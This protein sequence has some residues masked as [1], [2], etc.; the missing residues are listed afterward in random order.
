MTDDEGTFEEF[1]Q[2]RRGRRSSVSLL[3]AAEKG[4]SPFEK[5]VETPFSGPRVFS[6]FG[7]DEEE[8]ARALF[9]SWAPKKCVASPCCALPLSDSVL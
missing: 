4:P 5:Q 9:V 3:T 6:E 2:W 8:Q 1:L 7:H